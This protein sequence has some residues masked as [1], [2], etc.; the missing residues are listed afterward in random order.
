MPSEVDNFENVVLPSKTISDLL[1]T[2]GD[3]YYI[4]VDIEHYDAP[5]LKGLFNAGVF[6][7]FISAES[8]SIEVFSLLV[9]QGRYDAFK[10][11]TP[12]SSQKI[13]QIVQ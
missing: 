1:K 10:L 13:T 4:K 5:L 7:P 3:P 2:H 11:L 6:P 8:H 9:T 12:V